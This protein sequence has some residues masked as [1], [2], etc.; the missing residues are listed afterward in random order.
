MSNLKYWL[1]L[2]A[3]RGMGRSMKLRLLYQLGTPENLYYADE[4]ALAQAGADRRAID[5]LRDGTS[6]A[7]ADRIL[8]DCHRL[9]LRILTIQDTEYPDRL[10]SIY[11]PGY[12]VPRPAQI[13]LRPAP[14]V[15][16]PGEDAGDG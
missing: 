14:A 11:D 16:C 7:E 2:S 8:G 15:V 10:K 13:H 12:G 6:M 5:A 3:L 9:G 4:V 1:W